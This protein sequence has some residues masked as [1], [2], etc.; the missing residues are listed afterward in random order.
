MEWW[1]HLACE[2]I[3]EQLEELEGR[4]W[5]SESSI[6]WPALCLR[7]IA[8]ISYL[9]GGVGSHPGMT[10][11][12]HLKVRHHLPSLDSQEGDGVAHLLD[13]I[14]C[15]EDMVEERGIRCGRTHPSVAWLV[16]PLQ[17]WGE[18]GTL[19]EGMSREPSIEKRIQMR[20]TGHHP[21]LL[22]SDQIRLS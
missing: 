1:A 18:I 13:L 12:L 20:L 8:E 4:Q 21:G 14:E 5:L 10:S 2:V 19:P 6:P 17:E 11:G 9:P 22:A 15:L 7:P 3:S 16:R